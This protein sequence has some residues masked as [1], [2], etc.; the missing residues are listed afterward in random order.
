MAPVAEDGLA[1]VRIAAAVD[2]SFHSKQ[3]IRLG[4][5]KIGVTNERN[6]CGTG[7]SKLP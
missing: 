1:G 7:S 6:D 3:T 5:P 2:E 4:S